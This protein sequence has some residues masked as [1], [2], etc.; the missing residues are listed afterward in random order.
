MIDGC[1]LC[2]I[3]KLRVLSNREGSTV[4]KRTITDRG[5]HSIVQVKSRRGLGAICLCANSKLKGALGS[6]RIGFTNSQW[7]KS[8]NYLILFLNSRLN[9]ELFSWANPVSISSDV[10][11]N[12]L[13]PA[14]S[15]PSVAFDYPSLAL[16]QGILKELFTSSAIEN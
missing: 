14:S 13:G 5:R 6:F 8:I 15:T 1:Y 9:F 12:W 2:V 3:R 4:S 10:N 7:R 11:F 16:S